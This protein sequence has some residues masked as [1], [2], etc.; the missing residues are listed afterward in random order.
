MA[1][2]LCCYTYIF[3]KKMKLMTGLEIANIVVSILEKSL[4]VVFDLACATLTLAVINR[5]PAFK[6]FEIPAAFSCAC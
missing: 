2:D 5:Y 1:G 6:E 3:S 4:K